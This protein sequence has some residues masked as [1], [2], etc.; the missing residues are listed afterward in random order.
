MVVSTA[1]ILEIEHLGHDGLFV[2][3]MEKTTPLSDYPKICTHYWNPT[4]SKSWA[5]GLRPFPRARL[6]SAV[7]SS[8]SGYSVVQKHDF[9]LSV[10][11]SISIPTCMPVTGIHP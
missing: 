2:H 7:T 8:C 11:V 4:F 5:G 3:I 1:D 10:T 6:R 9:I